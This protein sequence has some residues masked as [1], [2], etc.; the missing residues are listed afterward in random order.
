MNFF[1]TLQN[2]LLSYFERLETVIEVGFIEVC[3]T[4][5][6]VK[7]KTIVAAIPGYRAV[8]QLFHFLSLRLESG[9]GVLRLLLLTSQHHRDS[10]ALA[11]GNLDRTILMRL[12]SLGSSGHNVCALT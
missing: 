7:P 10:P 9:I 5:G 1:L 3:A 6:I 8:E 12:V 2:T 4:G 11:C